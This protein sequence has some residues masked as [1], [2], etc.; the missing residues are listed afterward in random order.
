VDR[1]ADALRLPVALDNDGNAGALGEAVYGSAR[2]FDRV[3]YMTISTGI[4]TGI[5]VDRRVYQGAHGLAGE[6]WAFDPRRF[7]GSAGTI[8]NDL[9]S[10]SGL[11]KQAARLLVGESPPLDAVALMA[12]AAS[13][14]PAAAAIA[15]EARDVLAAALAFAIYLLD[16]D[17]VVLG[18]GMCRNPV[19]F[20][21]P[22]VDRV[23]RQLTIDRLRDTP[24]RRAALWDAAVLYGAVALI[25]Q[26]LHGG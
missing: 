8:I 24:I 6:I 13:G 14:D 3:F 22:V 23:R 25:E 11:V 15:E 26:Q 17:V 18:G 16:P 4:G 21:E 5:V 12:R 10:G 20:V 19:E 9:A 1:L 2:G 7:S